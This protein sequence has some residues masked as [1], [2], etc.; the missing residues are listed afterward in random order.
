MIDNLSLTGHDNHEVMPIFAC[1]L[2]LMLFHQPINEP[3]LDPIEIFDIQ[4]GEVISIMP[5]D[6]G[7]QREVNHFLEH[8]TDIEQQI[9]PIPQKGLMIK[10]PVQPAHLLHN[11]WLYTLIE[12][13]IIIIRPTFDPILLVFDDQMNAYFFQFQGDM[14]PLLKQLKII[15]PDF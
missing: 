1:I 10:I 7:I 14:Y 4:A 15:Q 2:S 12:E 8:L 5:N 6:D 11:E 13:T 9:N 3:D